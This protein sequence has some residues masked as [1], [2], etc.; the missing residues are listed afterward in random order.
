MCIKTVKNFEYQE[1]ES[2]QKLL[3]EDDMFKYG[4]ADPTISP[5]KIP[6]GKCGAHLHCQVQAELHNNL[7]QSTNM[8]FVLNYCAWRSRQSRS[9]I[10]TCRDKIFEVSR[11]RSRKKQDFRVIETV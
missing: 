5:S 3:S 9:T 4:S 2:A 1:P 8:I 10:E 6:C 11:S 7:L